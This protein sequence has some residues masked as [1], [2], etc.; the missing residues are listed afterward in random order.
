MREVEESGFTGWSPPAYT[1]DAHGKVTGARPGTPNNWGRWGAFDQRGTANLLTAERVRR[2]AALVR[3]GEVIALGLPI[4]RGFDLQGSRPQVQHLFLRTA[5][6]HLLGDPGP[7]DVQSADDLVVLPLQAST[8]LD[9]HAHVADGDVLY[10]GFWAGL[11][12]AR[13]GARRLGI[14]HQ[15]P[16]IVGRGV[17]LDVASVHGI[18][19][20]ET[21]I[22]AAMLTSTATAHGVQVG[23]GDILLVRTGYLGRWLAVPGERRRQRQSGLTGD[24][25]DWL[26]EA[27][28]AMVAAD[29]RTVEVVPDPAGGRGALPFHIAALR[30]LGLLIGELFDLDALAQACADD[31]RYEFLFT[32]APLPL[33]NAVGSPLNP[34]ALR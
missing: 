20:F 10:N 34:L 31:G 24:T 28:V 17:L 21:A 7:A 19:P 8:Q 3:T 1:V 9:G 26:A 6:D 22:D 18:D 11:V 27:D 14:H 32:A 4:G 13:S 2:A 15:G 30:D 33:V 5:G 23:A 29:N 25:V 12:T 16:G